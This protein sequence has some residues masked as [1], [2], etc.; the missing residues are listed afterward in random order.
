MI[1]LSG[2]RLPA[3]YTPESL[4]D[5]AAGEMRVDI[6][7]ITDLKI[8]KKSLDC[9]RKSDIHYALTVAVS[10]KNENAV[11][12]KTGLSVYSETPY[13]FPHPSL[14]GMSRPVVVGA[15]PCGLFAAL[16]LARAGL[17]CLL[18]EQGRTVQQRTEDVL[19]FWDGGE[20]DESSNVQYG[21]GGAGTFSDGKLTC[22]TNDSRIP[23]V[24]E[25]F[26]EHGAPEDILYL[27]KPHIGTDKL[28]GVVTSIRRE[29]I[30]LGCEIR[31]ETK[32]TDLTVTDG[33]I[34]AV[35]LTRMGQTETVPCTCL[36]PA[37]G[38][39]ARDTFRLL[40][41][42]GLAMES[43]NFSVGVRIE[44][45]QK[46]VNLAQYGNLPTLGTLPASDYK[47]AVHL[48]GG[49][50]V[51]SFCVCPGGQVVAAASGRNTVVTN[52]MSE[53]AR[54][55]I[56]INGGLLVSVSPTD[57]G[58][59]LFAGMEFQQRLEES[60]FAAGGGRYYAP[61]QLVGDFLAHCKSTGHRSV[62][63][64]YR[65]SVTYTDLWQVLPRFV[66][67]A[68]EKALPEMDK[69]VRGF[70]SPEAVLT[71]VETRSSCPVRILRD[72]NGMSSVNGIFPAGEGAGYAGGITSAAVDGI[73]AAEAVGKWLKNM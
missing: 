13:L 48:E 14:S 39:S 53:Y 16:M 25:T 5:K 60:A 2:L 21:E 7:D 40:H 55:K 28:K 1:K 47:L 18:I 30:S 71:A 9:R 49:R 67:E 57:F 32:L 37:L 52:G 41:G 8:L 72:E 23:F 36:I 68:L 61:A 6:S 24:L 51:Y 70:A 43:K 46:D 4:L 10:V 56:N 11:L 26:A 69:K 63:P 59:D 35:T 54:D 31:F 34:S 45:L 42:K 65:P 33:A 73:R 20:L 27:S 22:G 3:N 58:D 64:S 29:L 15:G 50:A 12:K 19:R 66:C 62:V 38:N 17:P 44:H